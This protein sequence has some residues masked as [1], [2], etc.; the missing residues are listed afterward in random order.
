MAEPNDLPVGWT[1]PTAE[2]VVSGV[3]DYLSWTW[4]ENAVK[5]NALFDFRVHPFV[6]GVAGAEIDEDELWTIDFGFRVV[7]ISGTGRGYNAT[8]PPTQQRL[9]REI[10]SLSYADSVGDTPLPKHGDNVFPAETNVTGGTNYSIPAMT[11]PLIDTISVK[12]EQEGS[13]V[14]LVTYRSKPIKY[15][16]QSIT[17]ADADPADMREQ[18][19]WERSPM[20]DVSIGTEG[21]RLGAGWFLGA[22]SPAEIGAKIIAGTLSEYM[23]PGGSAPFEIMANSVGD[24]LAS[25]PE[26][27]VGVTTY[28]VRL[29]IGPGIVI[30]DV[31]A[32]AQ[33]AMTNVNSAA[34]TLPGLMGSTSIP[35]GSA[36]LG[37]FTA[38]EAW[39]SD[40]RD[41]L[42]R[43]KHPF[44]KTNTE[45]GWDVSAASQ[46]SIAINYTGNTI[47]VRKDVLYTNMVFT[48]TSKAAGWGEALINKGYRDQAKVTAGSKITDEDSQKSEEKTIDAATGIAVPIGTDMTN[49]DV[50]R[51]YTMYNADTSLATI[52]TAIW[53]TKVPIVT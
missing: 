21:Y 27:R 19:P 51:G 34:L 33:L 43:Q 49:L 24:P 4:T 5:Y 1:T 20:I 23:V 32:A 39:W 14:W 17:T 41:W 9:V 36:V 30:P 3:H 12:Q 16:Y 48:I 53:A 25:P 10:L 11:S 35:K 29:A 6:M 42:P 47:K 52:I 28:V 40:K 13:D 50:I 38:R 46:E 8:T 22:S 44:S 26:W 31:T 45:L 2:D 18:Y 15:N 7:D 37:G